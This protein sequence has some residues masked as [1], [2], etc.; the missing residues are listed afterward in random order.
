MESIKHITDHL[1][2]VYEFEVFSPDTPVN[3]FN[4]FKRNL[5]LRCNKTIFN[6][7]NKY[8]PIKYNTERLDKSILFVTDNIEISIKEIPI[9][10]SIYTKFLTGTKIDTNNKVFIMYLH[11][12]P[13]Q[14]YIS[15]NSRIIN[16]KSTIEDLDIFLSKVPELIV[17]KRD[18]ILSKLLS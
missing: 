4:Y 7:L 12:I 6:F 8:F 5:Y 11:Y 1:L 13:L 16:S 3:D 15:S 2:N 17:V 14:L 9:E 10:S 18:T